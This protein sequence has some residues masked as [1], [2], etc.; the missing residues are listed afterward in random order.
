MA[1]LTKAD[2]DEI[3]MILTKRME[4]TFEAPELL[5]RIE[6]LIKAYREETQFDNPKPVVVG[7]VPVRL[8]DERVGLLTVRRAIDPGAGELALPGGYL[9]IESWQSGLSREVR[10]EA[11]VSIEPHLW[12]VVSVTSTPDNRR[13]LVFAECSQAI[14]HDRLPDFTS[15]DEVSDRVVIS[16]LTRLAFPTHTSAADRFFLSLHDRFRT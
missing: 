11:N 16:G 10:E 3:E 1:R 13:L 4:L 14:R 6:G 8:P 2:L 5:V 7:L 12:R 15:N 9:E